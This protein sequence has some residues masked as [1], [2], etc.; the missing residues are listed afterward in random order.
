MTN[1]QVAIA[2]GGP[3]GLAAALTLSRSMVRTVILDDPG[4]ARNA[5]SPH[6]AALPG[7]DL[8]KP[9]EFR[10]SVASELAGYG[11]VESHSAAIAS[12]SRSDDN[13]FHLATADGMQLFAQRL[14][15]TT[16][17]VD[18]LPDIAGLETYWGRS[19]INCP[20][21][22]GFELRGRAWGILANRA[23]MLEAAEIYRNWTDDLVLFV[24]PE[25]ELTPERIAEIEAAGIGILRRSVAAI[26]GDGEEIHKLALDD[27]SAVERDVLLV[28]PFQRQ[29]RIVE[30][31]APTMTDDGYVVVD[32]GFHTSVP[33]VYA[34]GD[35]L[36]A[37]HQNT[38]T[39][40]HM[41][42]MAAVS[43]VFD[44]CRAPR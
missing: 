41:G 37:G 19:V 12:I 11:Y 16:G 6:I 31:L 29:S 26:E 44:L 38:N 27:A 18:I 25:V 17:M 5:A 10:R 42:N 32:E 28:W 30:S 22:Q 43:M 2:G 34:A 35:L 23:G 39:A 21:C 36:Y 24:P 1:Y 8:T 7:H 33:N 20:F 15:L 9:A 40:L 14:L 4:P 13:G 3:A